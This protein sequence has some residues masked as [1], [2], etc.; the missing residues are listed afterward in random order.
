MPT[1]T[2]NQQPIFYALHRQ[3]SAAHA[4]V[5]IHGAGSTHLDW[6]KE[7]RQLPNSAVYA[8]DLPG[9]GRSAPPGRTT[10][11]AYTDEV[12]ALIET[13]QL[14]KVVLVGHSMGGAI[15]QTVG[16]RQLSQVAGLVLVGTGARLRVTDT[17]LGKVMTEMETAVFTIV[18]YYWSAQTQEAVKA[19]S[20][21]NLMKNEPA[22]L[23][24]DFI[25][26]HQFDVRD[27]LGQIPHPTLVIS[28]GED[29]MTPA[30]YGRFLAD[31][32]PHAQFTLIEQAAHMMMLERPKEVAAAIEHFL[33]L[34]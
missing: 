7:V 24:G 21:K 3:G 18:N 6:P 14:Q 19:L 8:L 16:L 33:R 27:R 15:A 9:H 28:A 22:T 5:L 13:L 30:K 1:I 2:I 12:V 31:S 32:L 4:V 10:I 29:Q 23:Y 11:E 17:I 26:C 34:L 25:A 20:R